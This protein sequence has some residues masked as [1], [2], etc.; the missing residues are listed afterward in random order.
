M[1]RG[2][3]QISEAEMRSIAIERMGFTEVFEDSTKEL[4]FQRNIDL[5]YAVRIY[6]SVTA[7][8]SR[9][10]GK[11]AIRVAMFDT[12]KNKPIAVEKRVNRTENALENMIVRSREVWLAAKKSPRCSCGDGVM[13]KRKSSRGSFLGCSSFPD[14]K[15]TSPLA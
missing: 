5:R 6:S 12:L 11:D 3:V 10:V 2:Y 4:M 7:G 13:V 15:K 14:C 8:S 9:S 1:A